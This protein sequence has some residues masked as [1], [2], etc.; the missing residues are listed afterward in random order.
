MA[1][2]IS[3]DLR[4][5][6]AG[7]WYDWALELAEFFDL[8]EGELPE[9]ESI[10]AHDHAIEYMNFPHD[11]G[12]EATQV[13]LKHGDTQSCRTITEFFW[14]EGCNR[15]IERTDRV[16]DSVEFWEAIVEIQI[17]RHPP[18]YEVLRFG[19]RDSML[20]ALSHVFIQEQP[21]GSEVERQIYP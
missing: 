6:R 2:S 1:C 3:L 7:V 10:P 8:D 12:V 13:V 18:K 21:D 11:A 16:G 15:L 5:R 19:R 20:S 9:Y 14:N 17:E 4:Y